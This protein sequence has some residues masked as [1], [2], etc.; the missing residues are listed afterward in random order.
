MV[1]KYSTKFWIVF[2]LTAILFLVGWFFFWQ[3][4]NRN[5]QM[6]EDAIDFLPVGAESKA[7]W[8]ALSV[9]GKYALQKDDKTKTFLLLFQNNMEIRPGGGY[10]GSFGILKTKNGQMVDLQ[11][12][13]LSNFDG[14]VPDGIPVPYPMWETL[15][16]KDWKMRDSNWSAD[17]A[18]NAQKAEE[19]Y[20]LGK[21]EEK[22]DGVVGITSNVLI[23]FLRAT[24]PVKVEEY[25]GEFADE[26][27]VLALE[28]QVEQAFIDQ[29]LKF[30]DRKLIMNKLAKAIVEKVMT[31]SNAQKLE[32]AKIVL[33]DLKRKDIQLYFHDSLLQDEAVKAGWSG[34]VDQN[35]NKDYLN[36]SDANLGAYKSDYYVK[37]SF[38][39]S[40]DLSKEIPEAVLKITYNHT[41]KQ[42]DWMT[43]DYVDFVRIYAPQG[44]YLT[45]EKDFGKVIFG[46]DFGKKS[47]GT[48][49]FVPL[50]MSKTFEFRYT[51]PKELN[52]NYDLKIQ[53][54][55]GINDVPVEVH[56]TEKDGSQKD[57]EF[58]LSSDIT[59]SKA[60]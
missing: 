26:N 17:F 51:L 14:R 60:N 58:V 29:G 30:G 8:K 40:V 52:E 3:I 50:N 11:T 20:Y 4:K 41:A 59:L 32:L 44:A 35:W 15:R 13:D 19:F 57:F 55:A 36:I 45:N 46:N 12:H 21:G 7:E 5:F 43:K 56:V 10:I 18:V 31:L 47:F 23:S 38:D 25:P 24:G 6:V 34:T 53:K 2:W 27:A 48:L 9:F 16:V 54:Q 28:F 49:L 33:E 37:R 1:K 39:Y 42:K 22:F